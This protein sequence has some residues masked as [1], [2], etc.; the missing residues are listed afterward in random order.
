MNTPAQPQ[1]MDHEYDGIQEYDNPTPGWWHLIFAGSVIFA[2]FYFTF[3]E[4]SPMATSVQEAWEEN[5][6][7]EFR[8]IFGALGQM[9]NDAP[10]LQK[11]VGD[12]RL[13]LVAK[14]IFQGNCASCHGSQAAGM[15][16]SNCPN[17]TDDRWKN[18]KT[19]T[20]IFNVITKG[21]NNGAMP[22][23]EN[24][25]SPNERLILAAYVAR[26]RDH[27]VDGRAPEGDPVGPWFT[28]AGPAK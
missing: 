9:N 8:K 19:V 26:L 18:V 2:L 13:M 15:A 3:A 22:A 12:E 20:D 24:R 28:A 11:T 10:T 7:E 17:L 21:A 14:G 6:Q 16:G 25:L 23:W 1:L 5:Q 27:P 4:Y